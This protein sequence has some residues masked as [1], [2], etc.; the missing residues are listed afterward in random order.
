[1]DNVILTEA[2]DTIEEI[3]QEIAILAELDSPY[4]TKYH[5]SY[6]KDTKLWIV[7]EFCLGGSCLDVVNEILD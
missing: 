3:K 2:D 7:M 5:G 6:V 1:M 4:I